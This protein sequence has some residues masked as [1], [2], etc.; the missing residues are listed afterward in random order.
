MQWEVKR[1]KF[2]VLKKLLIKT[3]GPL[4]AIIALTIFFTYISPNFFSVDNG[5]SL[6]LQGAALAVLACGMTMAILTAGIDLSL[7]A[8]PGL[9]GVTFALALQFGLPA[10]LAI[11]IALLTG[12]LCGSINGILIGCF[13]MDE[14]VATLGMMSVA[15]GFALAFSNGAALP[16]A[17]PFIPWLAGSHLMLG[18]AVPVWLAAIIFVIIYL[19]VHQTKF[20]VHLYAIGGNRDVALLSG[21]NVPKIRF[22]LYC[23]NGVLGALAGIIL[24]GRMNTAHPSAAIGMEFDAIAAV[25][26]GGTALSGGQGG[27]PGTILGVGV[28]CVLRSGLNMTGLPSSWQMVVLGSIIL[29][30]II[31]ETLRKNKMRRYRNAVNA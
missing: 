3:P 25:V 29:G 4:Y 10:G 7:G 11:G 8:I 16:V 24:V 17:N 12:M 27:V 20:G 19:L 14:F 26:I 21:V 5:F 18:I 6:M 30:T 13:K 1:V 15:E 22:F 28:V 9:A 31:M 2:N 23:L